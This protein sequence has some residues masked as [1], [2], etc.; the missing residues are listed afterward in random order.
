MLFFGLD[1]AWSEDSK[2][3][4]APDT[5]VALLDPAGR[6][7]DAGWTSGIEDTVAW[8][9][10][11]QQPD[12]LLFVDAPLVVTNPSGQ[13]LCETHVAQG[14][15]RWDVFA[16]STNLSSPRLAGVRLREE[17]EQRGWLYSDGRDGPPTGGRVVCEC[18]PYTTLVGAEELGYHDKRPRYKRKP[19]EMRAAAWQPLRSANCDDLISRLAAL[20]ETDP[21][22]DL[23]SH[24]ETKRLIEEHS[25]LQTNA[26]KKREDLIDAILCAWTAALWWRYGEQRSQVLGIDP[27]NAKVNEPLATIIA[28]ARPEQ[29]IPP[30]R[31]N[32]TNPTQIRF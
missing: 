14:Y 20:E 32:V 6:I 3:K 25:P 18:Y 16:N 15:W 11:V 30:P 26:Y 28:P 8:I 22:L 17:L 12:S 7:L 10:R 21:P 1:L 24:S 19:K 27:D 5:G 9:E 2:T 29:R 23:R 31:G 4:L 13:R